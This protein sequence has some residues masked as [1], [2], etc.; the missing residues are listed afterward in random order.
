MHTL[1]LR[2]RMFKFEILATKERVIEVSLCAKLFLLFSLLS[3]FIKIKE[4]TVLFTY[5]PLSLNLNSYLLGLCLAC[6]LRYG[7]ECHD[8]TF[9]LHKRKGMNEH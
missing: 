5:H 1:N 7:E 8:I 2:G 4:K 9:F 3:G 6:E